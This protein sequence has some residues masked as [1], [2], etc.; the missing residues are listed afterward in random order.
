MDGSAT[1]LVLTL[2]AQA[3]AYLRHYRCHYRIKEMVPLYIYIGGGWS[4]PKSDNIV[5]RIDIELLASRKLLLQPF[6]LAVALAAKI[7]NTILGILD[8]KSTYVDSSIEIGKRETSIL[9]RAIEHHR[10]YEKREDCLRI[11][12]HKRGEIEDAVIIESYHH[13]N[14]I[15]TIG[16]ALIILDSIYYG[17]K[18]V[19]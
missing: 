13:S 19:R 12:T 14:G 11:T 9:A 7:G 15:E 10:P 18:N 5:A 4:N 6:H 8:G 2:H 16:I 17:M 1:N 3:V